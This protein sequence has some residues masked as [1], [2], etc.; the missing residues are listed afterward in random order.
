MKK[1]ISYPQTLFLLL[2]FV[3]SSTT[4]YAQ[5]VKIYRDSLFDFSKIKTYKFRP[6]KVM[7]NGDTIDRAQ[8][9]NNMLAAFQ[10][11]FF[12]HHLNFDAKN[13]QLT[14]TFIGGIQS[15]ESLASYG[16]QIK[17]PKG[18]IESSTEEWKNDDRPQGVLI[19]ALMNPKTNKPV[20]VSVGYDRFFTRDSQRVIDAM[21][22]ESFENFPNIGKYLPKSTSVKNKTKA[23][24][25]KKGR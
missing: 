6:G 4:A 12:Q 23:P 5:T 19:L 13:G 14:F 8:A 7:L 24:V 11:N 10:N 20:W 22:K 2:A 21:F 15:Q 3:L 17:L 18:V 25:K 9:N 16:Q 1:R